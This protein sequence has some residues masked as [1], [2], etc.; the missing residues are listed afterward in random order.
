MGC[1][2]IK[3]RYADR[4]NL[5]L[6]SRA[7]EVGVPVIV[8]ADRHYNTCFGGSQIK[9]LYCVPKYPAAPEDYHILPEDFSTGAYPGAIRFA[10][11]SDHTKD[12]EVMQRALE[13]GAEFY[14]AHMMLANTRPV[15][16]QWSKT[17][18]EVR[19]FLQTTR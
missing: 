2:L 4:C 9:L 3:I 8:S 15:E 17:F 19:A 12:F 13:C 16:E 6:V 18:D 14:E 11:V 7:L 10:G 5:E 1:P